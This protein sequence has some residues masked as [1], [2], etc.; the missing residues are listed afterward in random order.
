MQ[1]RGYPEDKLLP[2]HVE[3]RF[4]QS[5]TFL[6]LKT[7]SPSTCVPSLHCSLRERP[8]PSRPGLPPR[9]QAGYSPNLSQIPPGHLASRNWLSPGPA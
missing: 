6:C 8:P 1:C 5:P 9:G 3:A 7:L 4:P 2:F